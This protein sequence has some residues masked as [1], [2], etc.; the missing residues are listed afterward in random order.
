MESNMKGVLSYRAVL[1]KK[2]DP[3]KP[4]IG[5]VERQLAALTPGKVLVAMEAAPINPSDMMAMRGTY[6]F[7]KAAPYIAGTVGAGRVI[8]SGG[9]WLGW[10]MRSKRVACA[11][12][13]DG[14]GTWAEYMVTDATSCVPVPETMPIEH[15]ANLL[16]NPLTAAGILQTLRREGHRHILQTAG[17][18]D[19]GRLI[20]WMASQFQLEVTS[21]VRRPEHREELSR[22]PGHRVFDES[23]SGMEADLQAHIET[24]PVTAL[25]D[26]ISGSSP[27]KWTHLIRDHGLVLLY[28]KLSGEDA[29]ID[30]GSITAKQLVVRGFSIYRFIADMKILSRF[31]FSRRVVAILG[32]IPPRPVQSFIR[33]DEVPNALDSIDS[34]A[35]KGKIIIRLAQSNS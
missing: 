24:K 26:P 5:L 10:T 17:A 1:V 11:V 8:E 34:A 19:I 12:A 25:V 21:L 14:D 35:H 2:T 7:G 3:L 6:V 18:S 9:G 13:K 30:V 31:F 28:G 23:V 15:T 16:S 22:I 27:R 29:I 32:R 20:A 33:L 4:E